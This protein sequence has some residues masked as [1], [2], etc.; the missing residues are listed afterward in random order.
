[1]REPIAVA[2]FFASS[3]NNINNSNQIAT[4]SRAGGLPRPRP[5]VESYVGGKSLA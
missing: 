2:P 4:I 1:M 5:I 3:R